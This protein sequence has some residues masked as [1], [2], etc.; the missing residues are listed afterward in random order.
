[1]HPLDVLRKNGIKLFL[2]WLTSPLLYGSNTIG[3]TVQVYRWFKKYHIG[4]AVPKRMPESVAL[5]HDAYFVPHRIG[6]QAPIVCSCRLCPCPPARRQLKR[7]GK[8]LLSLTVRPR[9]KAAGEG[10]VEWQ[11]HGWR[12]APGDAQA[13]REEM[14]CPGHGN[15]VGRLPTRGSREKRLPSYPAL[16]GFYPPF[17]S[18]SFLNLELRNLKNREKG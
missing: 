4:K 18:L 3:G 6:I 16:P 2:C 5:S 17:I 13:R 14:G 10:D 7:E 1:M 9:L 8:E 11:E 15:G 12:Q